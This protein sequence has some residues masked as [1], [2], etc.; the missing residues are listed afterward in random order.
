MATDATLY[1]LAS[2]HKTQVASTVTIEW[3]TDQ[4]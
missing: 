2:G 3:L 1:Q 4:L